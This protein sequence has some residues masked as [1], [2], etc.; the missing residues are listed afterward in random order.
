MKYQKKPLS[1]DKQIEKLEHRGLIFD[2]KNIAYEYLSNNSYYRLRAY[3]Y[4]F[5]DRMM[6][7]IIDLLEMIF[8][9]MKL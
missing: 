7:P 1:I 8:V 3:T 6:M 9:L 5:Q 2:D 4:P